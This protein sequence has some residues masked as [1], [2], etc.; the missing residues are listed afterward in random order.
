LSLAGETTAA[1]SLHMVQGDE[2]WCGP[3]R[4]PNTEHMSQWATCANSK[5]HGEMSLL[6]SWYG[7][8]RFIAVYKKAH[9]WTLR[10]DRYFISH[11]FKVFTVYNW[12]FASKRRDIGKVETQSHSGKWT[13]P[14]SSC[15]EPVAEINWSYWSP[16][17][18]S[19]LI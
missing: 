9:H 13:G 7:T 19:C 8:R 18:T 14:S 1:S 3:T 6:R 11:P 5:I 2:S 17:V 12:I 10:W 15:L 16:E 4:H